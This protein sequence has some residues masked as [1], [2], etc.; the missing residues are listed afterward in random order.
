MLLRSALAM[1]LLF[2]IAAAQQNSPDNASAIKNPPNRGADLYAAYCA[3]CHGKDAKG[4]G[5]AAAALNVRPADLTTLAR[6]NHGIFP[7]TRVYQ[8]II[9][10]GSIAAHGSK[11]MPMWGPAFR[12][13]TGQSET[14]AERRVRKLV[15]YLETL[16]TK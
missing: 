9:R 8:I 5:P 10:G 4:G 3:S 16:Q 11:D 2:T 1:L 14:E 6:S 7:R 13:L 15:D 12:S